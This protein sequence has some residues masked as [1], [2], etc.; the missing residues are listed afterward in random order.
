MDLVGRKPVKKVNWTRFKRIWQTWHVYLFTICYVYVL[1]LFPPHNERTL[2]IIQN[3]FY[4]AFS[5]G[6]SYFALWL[7]SLKKYSVENINNIPTAGQAAAVVNSLISGYVSDWLE[8]RPLI[9][10]IN[11]VRLLSLKLRFIFKC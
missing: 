9:I 6:D 10:V 11:M 3:S 5:W 2:K 4:G 8:N 7:Q 1:F